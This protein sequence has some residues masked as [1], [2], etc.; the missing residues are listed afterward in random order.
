MD[1]DLPLVI[2]LSILMFFVAPIV[3]YVLCNR[4][5]LNKI[6]YVFLMLYV[7]V[8]FIATT[9]NIS[10]SDGVMHV[11]YSFT[12]IWGNKEMFWGFDNLTWFGVFINLFMMI[13]VG[14]YIATSNKARSWWQ[15]V[16]V[17]CFWGMIAS[18]AVEAT[19]YILPVNRCVEFSDTLFNTISAGLGALMIL[20]FKN[21]RRFIQNEQP[22]QKLHLN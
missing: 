16:L 9:G 14:A 3:C 5:V 13:P 21:L 4:E 7:I 11:D 6:R 1:F 18:L 20:P 17:A 22:Q 12:K 10:F 2:V 8:L 15:T 19:Q